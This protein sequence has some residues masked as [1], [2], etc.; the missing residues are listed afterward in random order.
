MGIQQD[1]SYHLSAP[2]VM[3]GCTVMDT[4]SPDRLDCVRPGF[5][6]SLV[7]ARHHPVGMHNET[8]QLLLSEGFVFPAH[9]VLQARLIHW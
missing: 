5:S 6:A 8:R 3:E 4:D 1:C 9:I 7:Q 2:R